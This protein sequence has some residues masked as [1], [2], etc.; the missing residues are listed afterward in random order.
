MLSYSQLQLQN[1]STWS[2]CLSIEMLESSQS[3]VITD[4]G[5]TMLNIYVNLPWMYSKIK[6]MQCTYGQIY[7]FYL[8][9]NWIHC[10]PV[11]LKTI[12]AS[13]SWQYLNE[14]SSETHIHTHTGL[15]SIDNANMLVTVIRCRIFQG[16]VQSHFMQIWSSGIQKKY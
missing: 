12:K 10:F 4:P 15:A 5:V 11:I 8:H 6:I 9:L 1:T 14:V 3:N 7:S 13:Y 16:L 2:G